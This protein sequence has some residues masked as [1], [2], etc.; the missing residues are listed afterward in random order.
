MTPQKEGGV[1]KISDEEVKSKN[2]L[3]KM[4]SAPGKLGENGEFMAGLSEGLEKPKSVKNVGGQDPKF[5]KKEE[6]KSGHILRENH[7][8]K[9]PYQKKPKSYKK[10]PATNGFKS[11]PLEIQ[12]KIKAKQA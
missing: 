3:V 4:L 5:Q 8:K 10:D 6:K 1:R 7:P 2:S 12:A 11:L 9:K